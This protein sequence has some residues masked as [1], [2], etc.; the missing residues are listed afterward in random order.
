V[1]LVATLEVVVEQQV[2]AAVEVMMDGARPSC[3]GGNHGA[4]SRGGTS[5]C[6]DGRGSGGVGGYRG[7]EPFG[8]GGGDGV[9]GGG[10]AM[11][12]EQNQEVAEVDLCKG[13]SGGAGKAAV[14]VARGSGYRGK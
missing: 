11:S 6:C 2:F 3:G 9:H 12:E 5:L 8:G 4:A 14:S 1:E 7:D 13:R 10:A